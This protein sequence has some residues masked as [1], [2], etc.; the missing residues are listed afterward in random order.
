MRISGRVFFPLLAAIA[1]SV[2]LAIP[3]KTF[4]AGTG[5]DGAS[6]VAKSAASPQPKPDEEKKIWTNDDFARAGGTFQQIGDAAPTQA[7]GALQMTRRQAAAI[8]REPVVASRP[9]NPEQ[10]PRWY[11]QQV[12]PLESELASIESREQQLRDFRATGKGLPTGLN[13]IAPCEGI[14][15]DNLIA[16]FD[17]QQQEL[18]QQMDTLE[19][20]ARRNGLPP[21]ILVGG[22]GRV[23]I[24]SQMT[25]EEQRA[26]IA[27]AAKGYSVDK[28]KVVLADPIKVVGDYEIPVKLHREVTASVKITVKKDE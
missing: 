25:P 28:R 6:G 7:A 19:D 27:L 15:T 23:D 18:L 4:A 21:G 16:Q 10:D 17:A 26:A 2:S 12:G 1:V 24:E 22:R 3:V 8:V 13:I 14:S 11:A 9:I 5:S 20:T